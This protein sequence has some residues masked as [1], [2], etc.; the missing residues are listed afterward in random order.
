[1]RTRMGFKTNAVLAAEK[2]EEILNQR[3]EH[4][5]RAIQLNLNTF[6]FLDEYNN[7]MVLGV[8]NIHSNVLAYNKP[9]VLTDNF[10]PKLIKECQHLS[11]NEEIKQFATDG[12]DMSVWNEGVGTYSEF[13][14]L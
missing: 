5:Y 9:Q 6:M 13:H 4:E 10:L 11:G 12:F 14:Q 1:M 2:E 3:T 7:C 8:F